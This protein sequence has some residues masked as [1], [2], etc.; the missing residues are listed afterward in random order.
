MTITTT[1]TQYTVTA[2]EEGQHENFFLA[3][4]FDIHV[5]HARQMDGTIK[6][7][8]R[9]RHLVLHRSGRWDW[10]PQPSSRTDRWLASHR[11]TFE[12]AMK[13]AKKAA[14]LLSINGYKP[15]GTRKDN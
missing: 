11:F 8:V 3:E 10:E 7:A 12:T 2:V 13:L 5:D 9:W 4:Q 1:I 6:W 14:P 15:D